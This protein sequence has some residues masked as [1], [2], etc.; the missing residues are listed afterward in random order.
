[1]SNNIVYA[2]IFVNYL[3]ILTENT[4]GSSFEKVFQMRTPQ[5]LIDYQ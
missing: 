3:N 4:E 1:M 5:Y 2:V